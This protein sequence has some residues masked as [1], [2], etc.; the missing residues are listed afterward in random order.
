M[1]EPQTSLN[2]TKND[3]TRPLLL[4]TNRL[5]KLKELYEKR[6]SAYSY[7]AHYTIDVNKMTSK[8]AI[9]K[10]LTIL[11]NGQS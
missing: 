11:K 6:K 1:C 2:R 8:V 9:N 3:Q 4:N 5:E 10:I 7:T